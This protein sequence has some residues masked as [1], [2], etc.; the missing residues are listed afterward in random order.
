LRRARRPI[1]AIVVGF[2]VLQN[3]VAGLAAVPANLAPDISGF[4]PGVICHGAGTPSSIVDVSSDPAPN[5]HQPG[6][7][8]CCAFCL[9]TVAGLM[10]MQAPSAVRFEHSTDWRPAIVR[11]IIQPA[12]YAVRAGPSQA[13][14][15]LA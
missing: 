14:P 8:L 5:H 4:A 6:W 1:A 12:R 3:M 13:P 11:D 15:I 9:A 2:L 10:P 7:P